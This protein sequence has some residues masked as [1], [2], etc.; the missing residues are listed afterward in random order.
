MF[1]L[2]FAGLILICHSP[3]SAQSA[4]YDPNYGPAGQNNTA[5]NAMVGTPSPG[6]QNTTMATAGSAVQGFSPTVISSGGGQRYGSSGEGGSVAVPTTAPAGM[7]GQ[8]LYVRPSSSAPGE[9]QLYTRPPPQQGEFEKF[10]E[11]SLGRPLPRFGAS[12]ILSG[13]Q[14]FAVPS[15]TTVPPDYHLNPGDEL[16]VH[17]V[18]SIE[19]DLGVNIDS[20]GDIFIPKIGKVKVAGLQYSDLKAALQRRFDEQY[21]QA[22]VSV[23]IGHLHGISV[24]V[25]G[26]AVTPGAYTVSSLSTLVDAI[27][28]AGGPS[29][30]G[31]FRFIDLHR[32]QTL[33]TS[34]DLYDLILNGDKS[35][36]AI[37][38]NGDVINVRPVGTLVAV[39]GSVNNQAIY[40]AKPGESVATLLSYA[41]G[42]DSLADNSRVIIAKLSDLDAQGSEQIS[43]SQSKRLPAEEGELIRVLSLGD[44]ARPQERQ[45]VLATIDG[46]VDHPGR[47]YMP[48]NSTLGDLVARAGGTTQGAF[49]YGVNFYRESIQRQQTKNYGRLFDEFELN[50]AIAPLNELD[51]G[52]SLQTSAGT[53]SGAVAVRQQATQ[54]LLDVLRNRQPDGRLIFNVSYDAPTLPLS[55]KLEDNDKITIPSRPV[56]V[57]I[58]GAVFEPGS[59]LFGSATTISDYIK[60]AGGPQRYADRGE[61]FVVHANGILESTKQHRKLAASQALPG[62]VIFVP[63]RNSPSAFERVKEFASIIY[64]LGLGAASVSILAL[65]AAGK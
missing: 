30:G 38:Q 37:L 57:G 31:S 1:I 58:F 49:I 6:P 63:V 21:K 20:E 26:F 48:P 9:F 10:V 61:I 55:L 5:P 36:D 65:V 29:A 2:I 40:E 47:Y 13:N 23:V 3:V 62:D 41:G 15:T 64:E 44:I 46:E 33:V 17:V 18:G 8:P 59:V 53:A 39:T 45:A 12:L 35:H 51:K 52:L 19:G 27:L 4:V 34:L 14:G 7:I 60:F 32:G 50:S 56:T 16:I 43:L 24:Y 22:H 28:A 25:T 54:A 11:K 42:L